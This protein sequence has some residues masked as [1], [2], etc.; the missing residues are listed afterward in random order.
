M[1]K[2]SG[3]FLS[4][5]LVNALITSY[6]YAQ[7]FYTERCGRIEGII[8]KYTQI[9]KVPPELVKAI[10]WVE[11]RC[12]QEIESPRGA[13]GV[14]QLMEGTAKAMGVDRDDLEGNIMGGVKFLRALIDEC[15]ETLGSNCRVDH[16]LAGYNAGERYIGVSYE[17]LPAETQNYI[18]LVK[19]CIGEMQIP[20]ERFEWNIKPS[21]SFAGI[22][23]VYENGRLIGHKIKF[24]LRNQGK[25]P[26]PGGVVVVLLQSRFVEPVIERISSH[27]VEMGELMWNNH[28]YYRY[29]IKFDSI[30][31]GGVKT[32]SFLTR[33]KGSERDVKLFFRC[34][35]FDENG[36]KMGYPYYSL[37][38]PD[39]Y[40]YVSQNINEF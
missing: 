19:R 4:T 12:K 8:L 5:F 39:G 33:I 16:V 11:S 20:E 1:T 22:N 30:G 29:V 14:M 7:C 35:M 26:S 3:R 23:E 40:Y 10:A 32:V 18:Q 2:I 34:E 37:R 27:N 9:Y 31:Q 13:L 38:G 6:S 36:G 21:I 15:V 25:E 28:K 17:N 24:N